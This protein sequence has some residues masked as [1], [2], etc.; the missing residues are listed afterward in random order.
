MN[1]GLIGC[2]RV[3]EIHMC[4]YRH[5]PEA[6]VVAVSDINIERAK[7]AKNDTNQ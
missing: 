2:G 3:S 7:G 5:T 4:A 1:I 6:N